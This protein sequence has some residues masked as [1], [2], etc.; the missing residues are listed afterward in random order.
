MCESLRTLSGVGRGPRSSLLGDLPP[1]KSAESMVIEI[2]NM[3]PKGRRGEERR[4]SGERD[5]KKMKIIMNYN[6]LLLAK[7]DEY[8]KLVQVNETQR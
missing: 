6:F 5:T 2:E 3:V 4:G 1:E 7:Q 8:L